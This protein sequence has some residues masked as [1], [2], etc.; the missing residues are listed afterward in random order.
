ME[1]TKHLWTDH[2]SHSLFPCATEG[3]GGSERNRRIVREVVWKTGIRG[4]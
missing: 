3:H 1:E 4:R 2:S